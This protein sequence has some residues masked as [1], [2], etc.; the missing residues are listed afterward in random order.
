MR[1][2]TYVCWDR[3]LVG[4]PQSIAGQSRS[5]SRMSSYL[6]RLPGYGACPV[7]PL[8]DTNGLRSTGVRL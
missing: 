6:V 4:H 5:T 8:Q 7:L 3:H 2:M 1:L